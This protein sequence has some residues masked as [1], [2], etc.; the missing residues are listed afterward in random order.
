MIPKSENSESLRVQPLISVSISFRF[1]MLAAISFNYYRFLITYKINN[2]I[3][4]R[5][6]SS[7]FQS[8]DLFSPKIFP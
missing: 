1:Y 7:E 3:A 8:H 4:D 2:I 5:F 6:L